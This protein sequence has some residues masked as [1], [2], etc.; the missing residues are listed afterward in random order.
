ML[1]S[2]LNLC[3]AMEWSRGCNLSAMCENK[4]IVMPLLLE[5]SLSNA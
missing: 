5:H 2:A 3:A 4:K 1:Q